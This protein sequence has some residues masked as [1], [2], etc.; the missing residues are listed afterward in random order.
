MLRI[1]PVPSG[2]EHCCSIHCAIRNNKTSLDFLTKVSEIANIYGTT[3][4]RTWI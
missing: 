3:E 1:E 4:I 2:A